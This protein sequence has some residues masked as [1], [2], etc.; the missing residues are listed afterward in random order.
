MM[1]DT[2]EP[3]SMSWPLTL[4]PSPFVPPPP[5]AFTSG[6]ITAPVNVLTSV[7]N[8]SAIDRPTATTTGGPCMRKFLK[9]LKT[10][11]S[12]PFPDE[13]LAGTIREL[14]AADGGDR[15]RAGRRLNLH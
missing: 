14:A 1:A 11:M 2:S 13:N 3:R 12:A 9:P 15:H 7:L 5:A 6:V 8:A 10:D 4:K